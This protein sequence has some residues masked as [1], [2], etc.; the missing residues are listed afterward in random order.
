MHSRC[1]FDSVS[2]QAR[3]VARVADLRQHLGQALHTGL[4][5]V[6][7]RWAHEGEALAG[8]LEQ[9]GFSALAARLR[10]LPGLTAGV[11][12]A[13]AWLQLLA[14]LQ[15]HRDAATQAAFSDEA[16]LDA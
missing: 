8:Q 6:P 4:A 2:E 11:A 3:I 7:A 13:E 10:P 5:Q 1:Q 12:R 16:P 14:L 9:R 15:L